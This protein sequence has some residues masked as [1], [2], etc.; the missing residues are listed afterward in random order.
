[1]VKFNSSEPSVSMRKYTLA[2]WTSVF[3]CKCEP[4]LLTTPDEA[5]RRAV[6]FLNQEFPG[7]KLWHV[8][9]NNTQAAMGVYEADGTTKQEYP[10]YVIS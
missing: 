1:M 7:R 2:K 8:L 4:E 3:G 10:R 5:N 6:E 9:V